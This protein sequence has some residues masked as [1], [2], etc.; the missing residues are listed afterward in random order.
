[1]TAYHLQFWRGHERIFDYE[2]DEYGTLDDARRHIDDLIGEMMDD[3]SDEDWTGCRFD[4]ATARG[5]RVL[6]I[7]VL[8]AMSALARRTAH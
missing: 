1:M 5:K 7:P 3:T 8:A 2:S 4:V 6:Q